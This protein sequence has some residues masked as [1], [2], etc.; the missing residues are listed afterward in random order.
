MQ[1]LPKDW[2]WTH[3]IPIKHEERNKVWH[4]KS[5]R[6]LSWLRT[7]M[8]ARKVCQEIILIY[9]KGA[10]DTDL[11]LIFWRNMGFL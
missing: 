10:S 8:S 5:V 4:Q 7:E 11:L 3:R 2:N 1:N 9:F 6:L